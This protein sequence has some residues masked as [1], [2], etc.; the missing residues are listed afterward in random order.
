MIEPLFYCADVVENL[1]TEIRPHAELVRVDA[2][3][4]EWES[5][6]WWRRFQKPPQETPLS[7]L[8]LVALR[9]RLAYDSMERTLRSAL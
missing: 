8:E 6:R 9:H 7:I 3:F 4:R 5:R 2:L 1:S